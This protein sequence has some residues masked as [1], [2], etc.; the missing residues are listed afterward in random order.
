MNS[1]EL[2]DWIF[3]IGF[4]ASVTENRQL[5]LLGPKE[6]MTE[7]LGTE[8]R[9]NKS[10][11]I[12]LILVKTATKEA[13]ELFPGSRVI[14]S[15]LEPDKGRKAFCGYSDHAETDWEGEPGYWICGIC[16]PNPRNAD[17]YGPN[18]EDNREVGRSVSPHMATISLQN[19]EIQS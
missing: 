3:L 5:K 15:N 1:L 18:M 12:D 14:E 11:L 7:N 17:K 9:R 6:N 2:L 19:R 8:I 13:L 10:E 16:H 4:R